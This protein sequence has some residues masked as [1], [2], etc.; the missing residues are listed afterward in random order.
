[1]NKQRKRYLE[2]RIFNF[3]VDFHVKESMYNIERMDGILFFKEV[4]IKCVLEK[5][6]GFNFYK[7]YFN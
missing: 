1:M 5:R 3:I 7:I 6:L 2:M 4:L